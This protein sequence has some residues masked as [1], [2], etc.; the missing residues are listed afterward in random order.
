MRPNPVLLGG[1]A[2]RGQK[3]QHK[4]RVTEKPVDFQA[5]T[6]PGG[7]DATQLRSALASGVRGRFLPKEGEPRQRLDV[8]SIAPNGDGGNPNQSFM[9]GQSTE[10]E[11]QSQGTRRVVQNDSDGSAEALE[12]F[13]TLRHSHRRF[14]SVRE[15]ARQGFVLRPRSEVND[16]V[17]PARMAP[18]CSAVKP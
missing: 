2:E 11:A 4:S 16:W 3:T 13:A 1:R 9:D 18:N 7:G 10:V 6:R 5:A 8:V 12:V 14:D 17:H 15:G